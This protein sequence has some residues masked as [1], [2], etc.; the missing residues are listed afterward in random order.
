M[1]DDREVTCTCSACGSDELCAVDHVLLKSYVSSWRVDRAGQLIV[2]DCSDSATIY[3]SAHP[4]DPEF[5]YMC[6]DCDRD[7]RATPPPSDDD[8]EAW[9]VEHTARRGWV[10]IAEVTP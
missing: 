5:P 2:D 9:N 6:N 1:S 3:E 4:A 7:L 8:P 10:L